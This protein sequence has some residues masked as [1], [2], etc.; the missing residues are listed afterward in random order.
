MMIRFS[1]VFLLSLQEAS[2]RRCGCSTGGRLQPPG[3]RIHASSRTAIEELHM[4]AGNRLSPSAWTDRQT[5]FIRDGF[6]RIDNAFPAHIAAEARAILWR[7]TGCDPQDRRTWTRPVIRLFDYP[8]EPFRAAANT[9][10]LHAAFDELVG[11]GQW[12]PRRES[13]RLSHP[14]SSPRRPRRHRL[15]RRCKLSARRPGRFLPRMAHQCS[16]ERPRALDALSLL[17]RWR[18]RRAHPHPHRIASR[19]SAHLLAAAGGKACR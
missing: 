18:R 17:R 3:N 8:H 11:K 2:A 7:D 13:R 14:L 19:R 9:P 12:V 1:S 5:Q 15:A 6:V 10:A 16:L 4:P